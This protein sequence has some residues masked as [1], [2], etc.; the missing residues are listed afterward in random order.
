MR[1]LKAE[2]TVNGKAFSSLMLIGRTQIKPRGT[3]LL[4]SINIYSFKRKLFYRNE[5][6]KHVGVGSLIHDDRC[7]VADSY[8]K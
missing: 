4:V 1:E 6:Q 3:R 5:V 2:K 8:I 7:K